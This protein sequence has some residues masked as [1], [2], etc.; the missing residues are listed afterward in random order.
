MLGALGHTAAITVHTCT[1]FIAPTFRHEHV[2]YMY[3]YL[4]PSLTIKLHRLAEWVVLYFV[5]LYS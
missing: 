1:H 5:R 3:P 4:P 2:F